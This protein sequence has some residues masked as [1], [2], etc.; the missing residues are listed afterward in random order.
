MNI[1]VI[2]HIAASLATSLVA[3]QLASYSA[4]NINPKYPIHRVTPLPPPHIFWRFNKCISHGAH[5]NSK[6]HHN[7]NHKHQY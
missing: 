3:S 7:T 6:L 4:L 2:Y 5:N 1:H